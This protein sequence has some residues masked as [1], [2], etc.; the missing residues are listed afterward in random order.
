MQVTRFDSFVAELFYVGVLLWVGLYWLFGVFGC[1]WFNAFFPGYLLVFH[2]ATLGVCVLCR[3]A[4]TGFGDYCCFYF[5]GL[6]L[7]LTCC[8]VLCRLFLFFGLMFVKWWVLCGVCYA[9]CF[10]TG[11]VCL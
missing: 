4:L 9:S 8:G 5:V 10:C 7:A 11:V 6:V 2:I 1:V 3:C